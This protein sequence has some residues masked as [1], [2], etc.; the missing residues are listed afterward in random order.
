MPGMFSCT[1]VEKLP[2]TPNIKFT[3]FAIFDTTDMLGNKTKGGRLKFYFE[4]GDGDL[5]LETPSANKT[6]TT[7][8]FLTLFRK[9]DGDLVRI[10]G[11]DPLLPY[12]AYRIP[13]MERLGLNKILKGTVSITF[14]YLFYTP[15]D[16]IKYDF[17]ITDRALNK[18][19]VESTSE[20][21]ISKNNLY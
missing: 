21:I 9:K 7:N 12:P 3:S 14:L 18:S 1:K 17:Y 10:T 6:D 5:G 11:L 13:Y 16:T 19:N 8:M 4:D 15:T 20:I 2:P